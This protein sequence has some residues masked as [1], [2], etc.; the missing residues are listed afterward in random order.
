MRKQG[1]RGSTAGQQSKS[2]TRSGAATAAH[3]PGHSHG[4]AGRGRR[5]FGG[6]SLGSNAYQVEINVRVQQFVFFH[7]GI[8]S[9]LFNCLRA[10]AAVLCNTLQRPERPANTRLA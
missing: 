7:K 5:R 10:V 9:N 4:Q 3:G 8:R 6:C 2:R 1:K